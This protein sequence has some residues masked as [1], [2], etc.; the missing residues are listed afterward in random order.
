MLYRVTHAAWKHVAARSRHQRELEKCEAQAQAQAR[1]FRDDQ[2]SGRRGTSAREESSG[3]KRAFRAGD[4]A[5]ADPKQLCGSSL[6]P[7]G[8]MAHASHRL[9]SLVDLA[10]RAGQ[11]DA[12]SRLTFATWRQEVFTA[13][14]LAQTMRTERRSQQVDSVFGHWEKD[15]QLLITC[16]AWRKTRLLALRA[17]DVWQWKR[18]TEKQMRVLHLLDVSI[19]AGQQ[20]SLLPSAFAAW[21]HGA[22]PASDRT[23]AVHSEGWTCREA[24]HLVLML[25]RQASVFLCRE[26]LSQQDIA[27]RRRREDQR[28]DQAYQAILHCQLNARLRFAYSIWAGYAAWNSRSNLEEEEREKAYLQ[29]QEE[30]LRQKTHQQNLIMAKLTVH[31]HGVRLMQATLLAWQCSALHVHRSAPQSD[32]LDRQLQQVNAMVTALRVVRQIRSVV[33]EWRRVVLMDFR[34]RTVQQ[35]DELNRENEMLRGGQQHRKRHAFALLEALVQLPSS[36]TPCRNSERTG[37]HQ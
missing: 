35:M 21:R 18:L 9:L 5:G 25:W 4:A 17:R 33:T 14:H 29:E 37:P 23:H 24:C 19:L 30:K 27:Q 3:T 12:S 34:D 32:Q 7:P 8:M 36:P 22:S 26:R 16:A 6:A 11:Q 2:L 31:V 15:V 13:K 20:L 1:A 10:L 28:L